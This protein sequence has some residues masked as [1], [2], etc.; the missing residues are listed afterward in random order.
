MCVCTIDKVNFNF[1][2]SLSLLLVMFEIHF[3]YIHTHTIFYDLIIGVFVAVFLR[4]SWRLDYYCRC[5]WSR[6]CY[7]SSIANQPKTKNNF[8]VYETVGWAL[9]VL[10]HVSIFLFISFMLLLQR[11][12]DFPQINGHRMEK[13]EWIDDD[14]STFSS[15]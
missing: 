13:N 9:Y 8:W 11:L 4:G 1:I 14:N 12:V 3:I 2:R 5:H 7:L 15:F 10:D 6:C